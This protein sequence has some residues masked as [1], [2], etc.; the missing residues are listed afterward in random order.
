MHADVQVVEE[1]DIL[2]GRFER[3]NLPKLEESHPLNREA[4]YRSLAKYDTSAIDHAMMEKAFEDFA[5]AFIALE[6]IPLS[7]A[8]FGGARAQPGSADYQRAHEVGL[9]I[10]KH[11]YGVITGGGP[12]IMEAASRGG[13]EAGTIC[14]GLN[15]VL[16]KEQ[17]PNPY[18]DVVA[19][20]EYF[21]PRKVMFAKLSEGFIALPGGF[22]TIDEI[23]E[24]LTLRQ[25]GKMPQVP[26][27]LVGHEYWD[28]LLNFIRDQM[29][30][31]G[32]ISEHD[33]AQITVTDSA[34]EAVEICH[35]QIERNSSLQ[36]AA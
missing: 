9:E 1:H 27:V 7:I 8:V 30:A 21:F 12:G 34:Q 6:H 10:G 18:L 4:F 16:P 19:D 15:I 22:G 29:L 11:G 23:F 32:Y 14:V 28:P 25:T 33:L 36:L 20:F 2:T 13:K 26:V 3:K 5:R 31:K 24:I 35:R 17:K